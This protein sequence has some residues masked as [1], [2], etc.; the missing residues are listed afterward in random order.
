M[1]VIA[2]IPAR[3][4]ST[5]LPRKILAD[6]NGKSMLQRVYEQADS[7]GVFDQI[8]IATDSEEAMMHCIKH[9]MPSMITS[10]QHQSGTDRV[11][12]V[13]S[14][15]EA[16]VIVNIQA[17]EPFI[18][19]NNLA[20]L[21]ST[22]KRDEVMIGTLCKRIKSTEDLLDYNVVKLVRDNAGKVLYFSR[23]AIPTVR[24]EP[25]RKWLDHQSY[26][27]HLGLYAFKKEILLEITQLSQHE[28]EVSEKLEQLRWLG[29]G[30][31]VHCSEV[32]SNSFGIDTEEDLEKARR[33]SD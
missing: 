5:R 32:E 3:L 18:E 10:D 7:A 30:Y 21:V 8:M 27:Q 28:L 17:D 33:R 31:A 24:D 6:I 20:A 25:Y 14:M 16:D 9:N 4:E 12:E 2:I 11:A 13:A 23:Q 15:I 26:Y 22:M 19:P 1:K 29:N